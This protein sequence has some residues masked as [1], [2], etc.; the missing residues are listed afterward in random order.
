MRG[1]GWPPMYWGVSGEQQTIAGL[2]PERVGALDVARHAAIGDEGKGAG[3]G[4]KPQPPGARLVIRVAV[5]AHAHDVR[6]RV[7]KLGPFRLREDVM[8]ADRVG[9][10]R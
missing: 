3:H 4:P 7:G 8:E 2:S 9:R 5:A 10:D 6:H 1:M